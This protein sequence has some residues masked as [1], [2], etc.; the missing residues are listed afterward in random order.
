MQFERR[1]QCAQGM[2]EARVSE[3]RRN[4]AAWLREGLIKLGPTFIKIGQQFSTRVDVLSPEFVKELEMLQDNVPAF[5]SEAA[6]ATVERGLGKPILEVFQ[7]CVPLPCLI[8]Y[9][10][11]RSPLH[12]GAAQSLAGSVAALPEGDPRTIWRLDLFKDKCQ[13]VCRSWIKE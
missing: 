4:L 7:E 11:D 5:S 1:K 9:P 13:R 6:V 12:Y 8:A 10:L 3:R 2:T